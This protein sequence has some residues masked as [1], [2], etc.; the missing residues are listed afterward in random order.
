MPKVVFEHLDI[1]KVETV[2]IY[3]WLM[4]IHF[5]IDEQQYVLGV[6]LNEEKGIFFPRV[7]EHYGN[8]EMCAY[9][10]ISSNWSR[11]NKLSG[12]ITSLFQHL[13]TFPSIR[14]EWLYIPHE[15]K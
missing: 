10:I 15:L 4:Y 7:V 3:D 14:L 5:E 6:E 1:K 8:V 9:C 12:Q 11:C 2:K 13:L